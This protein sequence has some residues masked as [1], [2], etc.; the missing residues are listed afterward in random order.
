VHELAAELVIVG[1]PSASAQLGL[2]EP[3]VYGALR[4]LEEV[5]I[6][7]EVTGRRRGRLYA[8]DAYLSVLSEGTLPE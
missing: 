7:R 2:S 1:G 5:G 8:Y 4:R 6:L 3:A